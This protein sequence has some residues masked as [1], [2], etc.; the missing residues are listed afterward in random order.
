MIFDTVTIKFNKIRN[1][2]YE[3][4]YKEH[5][6]GTIVWDKQSGYWIYAPTQLLPQVPG[7]HASQIIEKLTD[8]K[9]HLQSLV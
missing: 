6:A 7:L 3:V 8:L 9:K 2:F 4:R 1:Y 5:L